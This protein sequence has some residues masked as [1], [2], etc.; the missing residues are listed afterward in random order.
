MVMALGTIFYYVIII[1]VWMIWQ[2]LCA[3]PSV[4]K[5]GSSRA[6]QPGNREISIFLLNPDLDFP[7]F[8]LLSGHFGSP[9]DVV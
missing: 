5:T 2:P 7:D 4:I 3:T 9:K 1:Y 6:P 8:T